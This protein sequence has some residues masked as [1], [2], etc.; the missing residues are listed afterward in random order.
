MDKKVEDIELLEALKD[1]RGLIDTTHI[2]LDDNGNMFIRKIEVESRYEAQ[3]LTSFLKTNKQLWSISK[4]CVQKRG[5]GKSRSA[6]PIIG[7]PF[8]YGLE[9]VINGSR[10]EK[11]MFYIDDQ[12][13]VSKGIEGTLIANYNGQKE[14]IDFQ[15]WEIL[16]FDLSTYYIHGIYNRDSKVFTHFDGALIDICN[17]SK[18]KMKWEY[19][20][21]NKTFAYKKLFRLDGII[22]DK[23]A[24]NMM[25]HYL[26]LE[27][28]N[29]EYGI[30]LP[31]KE[32]ILQ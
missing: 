8:T 10:N 27:E 23:D 21:P 7:V 6:A 15:L 16:P 14:E 19:H 5:F 11:S 20:I 1:N 29:R 3:E 2:K 12:D 9:K 4:I 31:I 17:E 30:S 26:P 22:T 25:S 28:L 13:L 18:E 32:N 24:M